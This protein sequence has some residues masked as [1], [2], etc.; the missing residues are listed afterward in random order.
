MVFANGYIAALVHA[1]FLS[2]LKR[3]IISL[4]GDKFH[5]IYYLI[6]I[7]I[8]CTRLVDASALCHIFP[9]KFSTNDFVVKHISRVTTPLAFVSAPAGDIEACYHV[10]Y[11]A[12]SKVLAGDTA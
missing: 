1:S 8:L 10:P 6:F 3:P 7:S 2:P 4:Q 9:C 12:V 5:N 11:Y